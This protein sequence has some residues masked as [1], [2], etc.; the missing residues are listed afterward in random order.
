MN[1]SVETDLMGDSSSFCKG[2]VFRALV[3]EHREYVHTVAMRVTL[4]HDLAEDVTQLVFIRLAELQGKI[5][6]AVKLSSWLFLNARSLAID[7]MRAEM[8]RT[9]REQVHV[10]RF[11]STSPDWSWMEDVLQEL[12]QGDRELIVERFFR[13]RSFAELGQALRVSEN[14]ARMKVNRALENLRSFL[15]DGKIFMGMAGLPAD[16]PAGAGGVKSGAGAALHGKAAAASSAKFL[17]KTKMPL[18]TA[19]TVVAVVAVAVAAFQFFQNVKLQK[20]L[21]LLRP[22]PVPQVSQANRP[23]APA[24]VPPATLPEILALQDPMERIKALVGFVGRVPSGD[25][26]GAVRQ[27]R[28]GA[29]DWDPEAKFFKHMLL[30]RWAK[31]DPLGAYASLDQM[32]PKERQDAAS[33]ISGLAATNP[34]WA[35]GWLSNPENPLL[36]Y[37]MLGSYLATAVGKEWVRQN[38]DA[39]LAWA[40]SLPETLRA[41]AYVGVLGTL[42]G[43]DPAAAAGIALQLKPGDAR[44]SLV[45][46]IATTWAKKSPGAAMTWAQSLSGREQVMAIRNI[47]ETWAIADPAAVSGVLEEMPAESISGG[48]LKSITKSWCAEAPAGA[49]A[50]LMAYPEGQA[51]EEAL[52]GAIWKWTMKNPEEASA[53]LTRQPVGRARDAGIEGLA[54]AIFDNDPEG[55][56]MWAKAISDD[57]HRATL[58]GIGMATWLQRDPQAAGAWAAGNGIPL[59]TTNSK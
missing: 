54:I 45:E 7:L 8:A 31:E 34:A 43:T 29:P 32:A 51:R 30:T 24:P 50:W 42:A 23:A 47:L 17:V 55:A 48:L 56:M 58:T 46:D 39:A 33:L 1:I 6:K 27:L 59:P 22:E 19:A 25:F 20:E 11:G 28:E 35:A 12:R 26:A 18:A 57:T 44:S 16:G 38:K 40:V 3:E 36:D 15:G 37:P 52:Q 41:G 10:E 5:P 4:R 21:L 14:A 2:P 9:R 13:K 49:A 53:W